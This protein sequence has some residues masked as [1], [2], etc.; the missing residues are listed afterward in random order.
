MV[1]SSAYIDDGLLTVLL[2]ASDTLNG[3]VE[4]RT[5]L[6]DQNEQLR[7]SHQDLL[8]RFERHQEYMEALSERLESRSSFHSSFRSEHT[9]ESEA[10]TIR[11]AKGQ[12]ESQPEANNGN[13]RSGFRFAFEHILEES[14]VYRMARAS[15]CDL[16]FNSSI[17]RSHAWT[18]FSELTLTDISMLSMIALPIYKSDLN[19]DGANLSNPLK[20]TQQDV[21]SFSASY[22]PFGF[23]L[24]PRSSAYNI[25]D[26]NGEGSSLDYNR[27]ALTEKNLEIYN[28]EV[29][30]PLMPRLKLKALS[31]TLAQPDASVHDLVH[32]LDLNGIR[33]LEDQNRER[34]EGQRSDAKHIYKQQRDV[35]LRSRATAHRHA[36][37]LERTT[38]FQELR[39][40]ALEQRSSVGPEPFPELRD[41][42]LLQRSIVG[43]EP[44]PE[45]RLAYTHVQE[46][47]PSSAELTAIEDQL[48]SLEQYQAAVKQGPL[49]QKAEGPR[50]ADQIP[51]QGF[52]EEPARLAGQDTQSVERDEVERAR[53][54]RV[55][56]EGAPEPRV[57]DELTALEQIHEKQIELQR[58]GSG[59]TRNDPPLQDAARTD[60]D[61][62]DQPQED[63]GPAETEGL[64]SSSKVCRSNADCW[65]AVDVLGTAVLK[66]EL[67]QLRTSGEQQPESVFKADG[68]RQT[69]PLMR[70]ASQLSEET[71]ADEIVR[72]YEEKPY[73]YA[74]RI[75]NN[76]FVEFVRRRETYIAPKGRL[77][78]P[79]D[80][81]LTVSRG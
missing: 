39:D 52:A 71:E 7:R 49:E 10:L 81:Y 3:A 42:A 33:A 58:Q 46:T 37:R 13:V 4:S 30:G 18:V 8:E 56:R 66:R 32:E 69:A 70:R 54:L 27:T 44:L 31:T 48:F 20:F 38:K 60:K 55:H 53:E 6:Q 62:D 36:S 16:S 29:V 23:P 61:R 34:K 47:G 43:P 19:V 65:A 73:E 9:M 25:S 72:K 45:L 79:R 74:A 63:S 51:E 5:Q 76:E 35:L 64:L 50:P 2:R 11:P 75:T 59:R 67:D 22:V 24:A 26:D 68:V 15:E 1:R 21:S 57:G 41:A 17:P 78:R 14:R 80:V 28:A 12:G 77:T 40:T